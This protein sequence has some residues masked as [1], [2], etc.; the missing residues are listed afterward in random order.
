MPSALKSRL[1]A[2][3]EIGS[4]YAVILFF[5]FGWATIIFF[6]KFPAWLYYATL[7][8]I[9]VYYLYLAVTEALEGLLYLAALL[10][11]CALLPASW[12]KEKFIVRGTI[13]A[14]ALPAFLLLTQ[15]FI[16]YHE[17]GKG[18]AAL[19]ALLLAGGLASLWMGLAARRAIFERAARLLAER[20]PVFL[21]VYLPLAV[22]ALAILA[23]RNLGR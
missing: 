21:Y 5:L 12:F 11:A 10:L 15:Y 2:R 9:A 23:V 1:P 7:G 13:A 6:W 4:V 19:L 22:V 18:L 8:E 17:F 14:L 16:A 3:G 20:T